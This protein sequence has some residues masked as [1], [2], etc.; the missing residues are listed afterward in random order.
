LAKSLVIVES[1]AKAKT[2]NKF[3]GRNFTVKAS[4]GHV[5]DL[6]KRTLGVDEKH[7]FKPTYEILPGR[8]KI[9][10]ELKKAAQSAD[11]VY[12]APD[13]DREGEAISWHLSEIL[14]KSNKNLH[15]VMFN[16]ITKRAVQQGIENPLK[17][18]S[19]RVDAQQ[20]RRILDRLV[21][22]KIS[23]LLW[24]KVRRGLSAGRV[25]SVALRMVVEREREILA[26][27]P[28]EYWTLAAHVEAA[29]PPP[30]EARL[31]K[32]DEHKAELKTRDET[33]AVVASLHDASF[34]VQ[35]VEAKEKKKNPVPPFITSKLQQDASRKLGFTVKKTM[36]LAQRLYEGMDLGDIGTVGLIT[37]MRTDSTRIA[38]E[39]LQ[40]VRDYIGQTHGAEYL[41]DE[42]RQYRTGKMAQEAHEAIRPTSM[43]LTPDKIKAHVQKDEYLLYSLIWNRFVA[44][45]MKSA[46]FDVTTA[47]IKAGRCVFR[48]TGST[49]KFAGWLAVYQEMIDR[50][51]ADRDKAERER[52][53]PGAASE[54]D[55]AARV[56]PPLEVGMTLA[57]HKL[58]PKQHFTQP[59][60]RFTEASLVKELEENGIGRPSTYATILSTLQNR[61]Y[62]EKTDGKFVPSELGLTVTDLLVNHFGAIVEVGYTARMEE[63]LDEIEEGRLDYVRALKDFNKQFAKD[64]KAATRNME[65][66]KTKEEPTDKVCE[67]CGKPMVIKWG[68]YGRFLACT[69]YPECKNTQ[70]LAPTPVV[71]AGANGDGQG[72]GAEGGAGAAGTVSA[73]TPAIPEDHGT[74]EKCGSQ[75]V[76]RRGRFGPFLACSAYPGCRNTKKISLDKE[77]RITVTKKPDRI[78]DEACPQCGKPLAVKDG[79]FGEFTACSAYPECRYIKLKEVGLD[80]P[81]E[82]CGGKIVER[83]SRRG[84]TFF[85][86]NNY[87]KCEFVTWYRPIPESCPSCGKPYVLEKTTKREGTTRF[88]DSE[89]CGFKQAVNS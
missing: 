9:I 79:R 31:F 17:I 81:R 27:V 34:V 7:D 45:Q 87:P 18:D 29:T 14:K 40:E 68:R 16:E 20:A 2:I 44:S 83:R 32:I 67:K 70:E 15:R 39:A 57:L 56:L 30:F 89:G 21:G 71:A 65:N 12:L 37:Y 5:R 76:L 8:K 13:P 75:M 11:K 63:E 85:G 69:G 28:E 88:C 72:A 53:D 86:C 26:F 41:P 46:V 78:L 62:V 84:R 1:P 48:A 66:I 24:E 52:K 50:E 49:M 25:Q 38:P 19:H 33:D 74:C 64:L 4:M 61:E 23:P 22:Y 42:P 55:E 3:L 60:P 35:S 59:P 6:P 58:D 10:D 47:D 36:T 43:E 82:G 80:C 77:G 51:R 73:E 54:D